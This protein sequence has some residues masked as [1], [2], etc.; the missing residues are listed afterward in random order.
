MKDLPA[1]LEGTKDVLNCLSECTLNQNTTLVSLDV[2]NLYGDIPHK[3]AMDS[4]AYYL[5]KRETQNPPS[6]FL[7][8]LLHLVLSR[9]Y[10][11][12]EF[13]WYPQEAGTAMG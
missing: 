6:A 4:A 13:N 2:E 9:N 7:L 10:M 11:Q 1:Y 5:S 8:K 12:Y 3:D